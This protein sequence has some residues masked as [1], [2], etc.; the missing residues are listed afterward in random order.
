VVILLIASWCDRVSGA[1]GAVLIVRRDLRHWYLAQVLSSVGALALLCAIWTTHELNAFSAIL[2]NTAGTACVSY[3]YFYR[4][5][6]L[7]GRGGHADSEK[8]RAI[9]HLALPSMPGTIFYAFQNQISLLIITLFGRTTAIADI[10]ALSRLA[11]VFV[12]F[13]QLNPILFEPYFAR[14]SAVHLRRSY[15]SALALGGMFCTFMT[16]ASIGFPGVFI[17]ILG[18]NYNGLQREVPFMIAGSSIS[19]FTGFIWTIHN[20]RK[21]VYWW[22]GLL[23]IIFTLGIEIFYI[24]RIDLSSVHSVLILNIAVAVPVALLNIL[25]GVCGF[26]LGPRISNGKCLV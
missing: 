23:T 20:A 15:Y 25:V 3:A 1:Y 18:H 22:N 7:V 5:R 9:L 4:A 8:Q 14:L 17:W 13:G 12:L 10:G 19:F 6:R 16:V 21:F 2:I 24:W 11:Q 26:T